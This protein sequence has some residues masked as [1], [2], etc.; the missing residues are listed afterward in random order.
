[1]GTNFYAIER[2]VGEER[3]KEIINAVLDGN[4]EMVKF[5][6]PEWIHIGKQSKGWRFMFRANGWQYYGYDEQSIRD[7]L[8]G[9]EIKD[10]Y[11]KEYTPEE[12]FNIISW[13]NKPTQTNDPQVHAD[14]DFINS[15]DRLDFCLTEFS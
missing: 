12:F 14:K 2:D 6:T 3:T 4:W 10:E 7:F 9:C 8:Q 11:D 5:L 13:R 15:P 1:M